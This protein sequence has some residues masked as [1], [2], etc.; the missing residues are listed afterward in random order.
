[1]RSS[2]GERMGFSDHSST[3]QSKLIS[4]KWKS[5]GCVPVT[6]L[7]PSRFRRKFSR[8]SSG[9]HGNTEDFHPL[10]R[11]FAFDAICFSL[12]FFFLLKNDTPTL[13]HTI[14]ES[15]PLMNLRPKMLLVLPPPS[16]P[17]WPFFISFAR[18]AAFQ[19][20]S[21]KPIK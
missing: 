19:F 6:N 8:I 2:R 16:P 7:P 13:G 3:A 17:A 14:L 21:W 5:F 20:A 15:L 10:R 1:M 12:E 4:L 18:L 9:R 11:L